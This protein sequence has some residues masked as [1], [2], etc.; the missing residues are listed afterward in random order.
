LSGL[1]VIVVSLEVTVDQL[2]L[3]RR[4]GRMYGS[5]RPRALRKAKL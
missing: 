5:T 1:F 3:F 4:H 2:V